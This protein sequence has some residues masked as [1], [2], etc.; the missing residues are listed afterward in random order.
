[1][2]REYVVVLSAVGIGLCT[3][4]GVGI[5]SQM[6][7][8]QPLETAVDGGVRAGLIA[9]LVFLGAEYTRENVL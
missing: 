8:N 3:A 1:M 9:A 5:S 7:L 6:L 2:K 4:L